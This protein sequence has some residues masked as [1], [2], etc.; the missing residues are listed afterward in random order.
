MSSVY[1]LAALD[2][3]AVP[4][5]EA[6][7]EWEAFGAI[8]RLAGAAK[9][10]LARRVE[11]SRVWQ[12]KGHSSAADYLAPK[13]G[14]GAG[15]ARAELEAS[16]RVAGLPAT[17]AALRAGALSGPQVQVIA[18]GAS[19]NRGAEARL[20]AQAERASLSELRAECARAKAAADPD[21]DARYQRIRRAR[22]LRR[23]C[24]SE[25]AWNLYARGPV[26]AG[27]EVEAA[28]EPLIEERFRSARAKGERE[29]REAY[30]FDALVEL[31][32]R[33]R[34]AAPGAPG[35][36]DGPEG[37][38][39]QARRDRPTYLVLLRADL[40]ALVRGSLEGYERCEITGLGPVPVRT[41]R[42]LL[43]D[44]VLK[45][46]LTRGSDVANVT[47][48]GRGPSAAQ[49]VALL[50]SQPGCT[51]EGCHRRRVEIDHRVPWAETRRTRLGELD[52][53]CPAHHDLKT[54][55]GWA[56]VEGAGK[57]PMVPPDHPAH[58]AKTRSCER[59][60]PAL[61]RS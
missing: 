33:S 56:L 19:V 35:V 6:P 30:A 4:L 37:H 5:P 7:G 13:A 52:A 58:P 34:Q 36:G 27:A 16:K 31:A 25:G 59:A 9:T 12:R 24:D 17:T 47:H 51:V 1:C 2:P 44:A 3:E 53:L 21:P 32:R 8:E 14:A 18:D 54:H 45:L 42:E 15:A 26:D 46:V 60:P 23:Y 10:L 28:L 57:R 55:E 22:R 50:W 39:E 20:L 40:E 41:A 11:E 43:G 61:A 38:R 29:D 49:R 48:L